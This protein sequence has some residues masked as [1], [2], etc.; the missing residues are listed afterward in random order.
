MGTYN[1]RSLNE[2][3]N[4]MIDVKIDLS[5]LSEIRS[6]LFFSWSEIWLKEHCRNSWYIETKEQPYKSRSLAIYFQDPKEAVLFKLSPFCS[7]LHFF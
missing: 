3:V 6:Y 4:G 7:S 2:P 5:K 1:L